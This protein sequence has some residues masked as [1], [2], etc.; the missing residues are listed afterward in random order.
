MVVVLV[1]WCGAASGPS[2]VYQEILKETIQ[3][4]VCTLKL[5]GAWVMQHNN[6]VKHTNK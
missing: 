5:N 2:A 3:P 6:N 1:W 4:S